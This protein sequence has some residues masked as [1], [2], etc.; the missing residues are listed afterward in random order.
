MTIKQ[1]NATLEEKAD[2]LTQINP[3]IV[4]ASIQSNKDIIEIKEQL[5]PEGGE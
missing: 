2:S 5:S 4:L 3:K 1:E